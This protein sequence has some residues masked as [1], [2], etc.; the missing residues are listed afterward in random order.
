MKIRDQYFIPLQ[1]ELSLYSHIYSSKNL[2]MNKDVIND[3]SKFKRKK[4]NMV[5]ELRR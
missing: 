3:S 2:L 4:K 5:I 1:Q